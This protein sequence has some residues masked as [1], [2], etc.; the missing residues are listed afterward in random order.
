MNRAAA[1]AAFR[2]AFMAHEDAVAEH[3]NESC[4]LL[5]EQREFVRAEL[6]PLSKRCDETRAELDKARAA[7]KGAKA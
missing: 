4:R 5:D 3:H 7:L 6:E 2:V 1:E